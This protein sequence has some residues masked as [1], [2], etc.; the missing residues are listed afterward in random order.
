MPGT[1]LDTLQDG[2]FERK[3]LYRDR[4]ENNQHTTQ[5]D[6]IYGGICAKKCEAL[7]GSGQ[8]GGLA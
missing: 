7:G 2:A 1:S 5:C 6:V 4:D 8:R 3:T